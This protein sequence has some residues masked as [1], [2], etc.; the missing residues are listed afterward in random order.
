VE[1]IFIQK[2]FQITE[3]ILRRDMENDVALRELNAHLKKAQTMNFK[4]YEVEVLNTL[5]ILYS[6]QDDIEQAKNYS[7]E[8]L[9]KAQDVDDPDLSVKLANNLAET[10]LDL[11]DVNEAIQYAERGL[12]IVQKHHMKTL[13]TLYIYGTTAACHMAQGHFQQAQDIS[14][15]FW[16]LAQGAT[17]QKYS[18]YEYAQIITLMHE[19]RVQL[20]LV[21][22]DDAAFQSDIQTL[23][24]FVEQMNREDFSDS[25]L[26]QGLYYALII[27]NDEAAAKIWE[28]NLLLRHPQGLRLNQLL[29]MANF[30][31]YNQQC[32]WARK[33]AQQ[34]LDYAEDLF[35]PEGIMARAKDILSANC[36]KETSPK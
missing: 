4:H 19:T 9:E 35:V 14:K 32:A 11:G 34:I 10:F 25:L 36:S 15:T 8:A 29:R 5:S 3:R 17:L 21:A 18:R 31:S 7:L 16:S 28:K 24:S 27:H 22:R 1:K 23:A 12:S 20:D 26:I 30:L 2:I 33:Y 13:L 6:M